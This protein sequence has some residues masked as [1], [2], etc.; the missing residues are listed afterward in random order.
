MRQSKTEKLR[1]QLDLPKRE[2]ETQLDR[3]INAENPN[4]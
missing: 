4:R 1:N 3:L 2:K